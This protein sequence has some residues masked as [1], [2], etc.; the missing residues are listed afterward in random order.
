MHNLSVA[1]VR[2]I[3]AITIKKNISDLFAYTY[4]SHFMCDTFF[5]QN[6]LINFVIN[7]IINANINTIINAII[8]AIINAIISAIMHYF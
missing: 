7:A 5:L 4:S 8:S 6:E 1:S 2:N 3:F